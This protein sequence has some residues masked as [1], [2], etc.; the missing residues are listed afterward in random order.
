V[1]TVLGFFSGAALALLLVLGVTLWTGRAAA[2]AAPMGLRDVT[3]ATDPVVRRETFETFVTA[4]LKAL[5]YAPVPV[6]RPGQ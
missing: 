4:P 2:A 1:R 3:A 5:R 6:D